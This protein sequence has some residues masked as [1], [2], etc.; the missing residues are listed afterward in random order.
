MNSFKVVAIRTEVAQ[1]VQRTG[2]SP[3]YGFPAH[4]ELATS[5]APCRHCLQLIREREEELL[6]VTYDPFR[7][8]NA[9]PLPGPVY[10]HAEAC[11][12]YRAQSLFPAIFRGRQLTLDAYR[13]DGA[14]LF[15]AFAK[16][17]NEE[18]V[19]NRLFARRR[20]QFIQVRSTEAGCFLFRLERS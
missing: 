1:Y 16:D 4:K 10:L 12:R 20:V 5:R 13:A 6:L 8:V 17:G 11:P 7:D 14:F 18:Q 19:A 3:I 2:K 9:L 15:E